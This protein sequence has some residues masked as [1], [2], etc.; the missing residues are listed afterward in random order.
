MANADSYDVVS[1]SPGFEST[2]RKHV[3]P[4]RQRADRQCRCRVL[5]A[6][7]V[8]LSAISP[9]TFYIFWR[10]RS[11]NFGWWANEKG[12]SARGQNDARQIMFRQVTAAGRN[13]FFL[14]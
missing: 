4:Q 5:G 9:R 6:E 7:V 14:F 2:R 10:K 11:R 1:T 3:P 8:F 13:I 12:V